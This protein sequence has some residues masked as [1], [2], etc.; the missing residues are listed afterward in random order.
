M[1]G[2]V[3]VTVRTDEESVELEAVRLDDRRWGAAL[4]PGVLWL[5][6]DV[7]V[8]VA[9]GDGEVRPATVSLLRS[10]RRWTEVRGRLGQDL[11][12]WKR[13]FVR[14]PPEVVLLTLVLPD[15]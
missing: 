5:D 12:V 13:R 8:G 3:R 6:D 9:V 2:G 7:E 15:G 1:G 4:P 14:P 10:G 11:P